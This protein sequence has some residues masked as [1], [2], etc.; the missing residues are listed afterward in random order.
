MQQLC[1]ISKLPDA[2]YF[3]PCV[4][5]LKNP[6]H[7]T[8][9]CTERLDDIQEI[10]ETNHVSGPLII[11]FGDRVLPRGLFC[12]MVVILSNNNYGWQLNKDS[13]SIC[14]RNLIEFSV[15]ITESGSTSLQDIS[16][17]SNV[18]FDKIT[19]IEVLTTC[20]SDDC[21]L[22]SQ[23]L[24]LALYEACNI[25]KYNPDNFGIGKGFNNCHIG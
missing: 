23:A 24:E 13:E 5:Q 18:I 12:A 15:N 9:E 22:I 25:L 11:S 7:P 4:L 1:I 10:M 21:F 14:R 20:P 19:H 8:P 17:A 3:M 16:L 6:Q 2:S